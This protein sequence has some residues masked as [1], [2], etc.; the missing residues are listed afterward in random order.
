VQLSQRVV[1]V[2]RVVVVHERHDRH[3]P[4]QRPD[5]LRVR[6][7]L[8]AAVDDDVIQRLTRQVRSAEV[9]AEP[10][11]KAL[12]FRAGGGRLAA[13]PW[14]PPKR[15]CGPY[16]RLVG[17]RAV[18][19]STRLR[20][21]VGRCTSGPRIVPLLAATSRLRGARTDRGG[22]PLATLAVE[23]VLPAVQ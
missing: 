1:R 17:V 14:A 6:L 3:A 11:L 13:S 5:R 18:F 12:A 22:P 19:V 23:D 7:D 4:A 2:P 8:L 9:P 15:G 16:A 10:E 20:M 21:P